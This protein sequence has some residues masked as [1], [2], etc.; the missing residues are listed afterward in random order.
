M[1]LIAYSSAIISLFF[2]SIVK[3]ATQA[4][5]LAQLVIFPQ[6]LFAGFFVPT[7]L[8]PVIFS[9]IQWIVPLKYGLSIMTIAEFS[10]TPGH[11]V[12]YAMNSV[13]PSLMLMYVFILVGLILVLRVLSTLALWWRSQTVY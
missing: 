2:A 11:E 5:E 10:G 4:A 13:N 7:T 1:F 9:W 3:R 8:M 12:L 6:I